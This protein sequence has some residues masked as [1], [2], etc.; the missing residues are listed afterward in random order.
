MHWCKQLNDFTRH[1]AIKYNIMFLKRTTFRIIPNEEFIFI[2]DDITSTFN[3][4]TRHV[5]M[6]WEC[7]FM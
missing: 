5:I 3:D 7:G 6:K 1:Y 2:E 4:F